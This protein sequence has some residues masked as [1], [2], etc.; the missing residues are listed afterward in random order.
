MESK[1]KDLEKFE[2]LLKEFKDLDLNLLDIEDA[3]LACKISLQ[4]IKIARN[5]AKIDETI[6]NMSLEAELDSSQFFSEI[7][8]LEAKRLRFKEEAA[9]CI[10]TKT[11]SK[12]ST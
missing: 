1:T 6:L 2:N 12:I 10:Q 3:E 8:F 4:K 11:R 7:L 9:K 5:F